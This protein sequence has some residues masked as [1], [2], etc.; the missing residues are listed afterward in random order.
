METFTFSE[1]KQR[2]VEDEIALTLRN[3]IVSGRFQPG[4]RINES[5]VAKQM[6]VSRIPIREAIK[7]LEQEGLLVRYPNRRVFVVSFSEKDVMEVFSLRSN[8]ECMTFEWA[9]PN[10]GGN[11]FNVLRELISQQEGAISQ[12]NYEELARLDMRFH[13]YILNK[14]A[15]SR[16]LKSWY[17]QHAQCQ[18]LLNL[19]FR[20]MPEYTPETVLQ[21]HEAI[22]DAMEDGNIQ[23]AISLTKQ[24]SERVADECIQT[25]RLLLEKEDKLS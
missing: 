4:S 6:N 21:D 24:I 3:A 16:L 19:R 18:M 13:E 7:K 10:M 25:L 22:L 9:L 2:T 15:H 20:T 23:S 1:V 5:E 8:L 11:D 12:Q 17:E 14:A